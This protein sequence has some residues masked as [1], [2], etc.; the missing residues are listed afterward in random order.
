M[1][2]ILPRLC[3]PYRDP[4]VKEFAEDTSGDAIDRLARLMGIIDLLSLDH[5][6]FMIQIAAPQLIQEAP[7]YEQRTFERGVA[8][9]TITLG[10]TRRFW[11][12][13]STISLSTR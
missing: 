7:G 6:N 1:N 8:D 5:T 2:N 12:T 9:G 13:Q 11:R 10:K 4:V 3:A